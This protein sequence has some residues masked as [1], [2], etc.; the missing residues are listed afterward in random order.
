MLVAVQRRHTGEK[1]KVVF[2]I[3]AW[4]FDNDLKDFSVYTVHLQNVYRCVLIIIKHLFLYASRLLANF[5]CI[6]CLLPGHYGERR[7]YMLQMPQVVF[8]D[9]KCSHSLHNLHFSIL[10]FIT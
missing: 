1:E 4:C 7:S 3:Y 10:T 5:L 8:L 6:A 2:V 9:P